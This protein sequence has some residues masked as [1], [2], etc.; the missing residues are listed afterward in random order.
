[1]AGDA[2]APGDEGGRRAGAALGGKALSKQVMVDGVKLR[3]ERRGDA[4]DARRLVAGDAWRDLCRAL[5]RAGDALL[6]AENPAD[7]RTRA[8]GFRYLLGLATVGIRQGFELADREHPVF[9]RIEDPWAKWGA[10]NADNHYLHA[11]VRSDRTYRIRGERGTCLDFLIEVKEGFMHLGDV[12]NFA[13]LAAHDLRIEPDGSFE[14][15]ASR[16][17]TGAAEGCANWLPLHPDAAQITIRE[18]LYDWSRE[19]PARFTIECI[20]AAGCAPAPPDAAATARVLDDVGHFVET[21]TRFWAEW[22]PELRDA[23]V[24]GRLAPARMFVGGAD[25]IRYG[26]DLYRLGE[27]EALVI[28]TAVPDARYWH[29]QLCNEWFVTMDYANRQTSLNGAQLRIDGDGLVRIV[30]AHEDPGVPNWLD[31]GGAREGMIQYR[32][33]WTKDAPQPRIATVPLGELRAHLPADTPH[34][35]PAE[36]RTRIAERQ[37]AIARRMRV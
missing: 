29:Y 21:T 23:H 18:Y 13:T 32:Y 24:P 2:G 30:V 25:D 8:E 26:N 34:V 33:V 28:E 35:P 14:I 5:E 36:R 11:H 4:E 15:V 20:E 19:E 31:T 1:M 10:E 12:R 22:V 6:A 17:R 37:R 9:V 27:G 16:E 3:P 7:E